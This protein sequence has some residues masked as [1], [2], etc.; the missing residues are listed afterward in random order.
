MYKLECKFWNPCITPPQWILEV[1]V[2]LIS[3]TENLHEERVFLRYYLICQSIS[4][5][6]F[7]KKPNIVLGV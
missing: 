7:L 6:F 3:K 4:N 1:S 2:C 5:Y